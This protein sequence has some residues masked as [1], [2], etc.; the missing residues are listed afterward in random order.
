MANNN[1]KM[2][3]MFL[4]GVENNPAPRSYADNIRIGLEA[5]SMSGGSLSVI[6]FRRG[7]RTSNLHC[8]NARTALPCLEG[9]STR[10][11]SKSLA[12]LPKSLVVFRNHWQTLA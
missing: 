11:F 5:A 3:P 7:C 2:K 10:G 8:E 4:P 6:F 9:R 1:P 12:Y